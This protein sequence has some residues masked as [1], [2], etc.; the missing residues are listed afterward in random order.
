MIRP[1]FIDR[2]TYMIRPVFID[3]ITYM[4]RPV[5]IDRITYMIRPV[6]IDRITYMIRS[7][8]GGFAPLQPPRV[9]SARKKTRVWGPMAS[10]AIWRGVASC[11]VGAG[12]YAAGAKDPAW[13]VR[14]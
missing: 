13:T 4:I 11:V 14:C 8:Q 10:G 7:G 2:I 6:F 1:V 9:F 12:G 3:R 5:F